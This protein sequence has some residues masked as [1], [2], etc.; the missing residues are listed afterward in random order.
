MSNN[1]KNNKVIGI[2][3]K[4]CIDGTTAAAVLLGKFPNIQFFP[5]KHGYTNE[6]IDDLCTQ[7]QKSTVYIVDFS[8][9]EGHTEKLLECAEKIINIDHHIGIH[10][11]L[12]NMDREFTNFNYVF[13]NDRS[14]ASLVW[15]YFYGSENIPELILLVEDGDIGKWELGEKTN[16]SGGYLIPLVNK[17]KEVV[18][19]F[20]K[21]INEILAHGKKI[22]SFIDHL[23]QTFIEHMEPVKLLIGGHK[24]TAYNATYNVERIRSNI[25]YLLV[26]K[27]NETIGL[28]RITGGKV[29]F[30]FRGL[31]NVNPSALELAKILGGGGHRNSAGA[32]VTSK[33][34]SNMT[35]EE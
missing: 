11:K 34:F 27:H 2:Y 32:Q 13:D 18:K 22:S 29:N 1:S 15:I 14:G 23:I 20:E 9:R 16:H 17:P 7:V 19:L 26:R 8:L 31:D 12:Q 24:I 10:E 28:F 5:L 30:S 6:T 33:T 3:H 25:G 21:P 4:D 35:V